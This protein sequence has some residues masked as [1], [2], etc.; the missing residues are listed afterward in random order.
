VFTVYIQAKYKA[1]TM[2]SEEKKE[3]VVLPIDGNDE[4]KN[5]TSA[6]A[7]LNNDIKTNIS[8]N[9]TVVTD[10]LNNSPKVINTPVP[11]STTNTADTS[12][13][14]SPGF[15]SRI[16][17][18]GNSVGSGAPLLGD[19]LGNVYEKAQ[20]RAVELHEQAVT[21]VER[22]RQQQ[23]ED[24]DKLNNIVIPPSSGTLIVDGSEVKA[25]SSSELQEA[26]NE[27]KTTIESSVVEGAVKDGNASKVKESKSST[28]PNV[29]SPLRDAFNIV[30]QQSLQ[31]AERLVFPVEAFATGV[32]D[33]DATAE[34]GGED[35]EDD[36][37]RYLSPD[38]SNV[39]SSR[40]QEDDSSNSIVGSPEKEGSERKEVINTTPATSTSSL[41]PTRFTGVFNATVGRY[42]RRLQESASFDSQLS[43]SSD[44]QQSQQQ[45]Q[46]R[47]VLVGGADRV[48]GLRYFQLDSIIDKN[49]MSSKLLPPT[50][51]FSSKVREICL[52]PFIFC[53]CL[54]N[55]LTNSYTTNIATRTR[56][57]SKRNRRTMD[58]GVK[59]W[60]E[61]SY[62]SSNK[63]SHIILKVTTMGCNEHNCR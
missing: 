28:F 21:E 54:Y 26:S 49:A 41:T 1:V 43:S 44:Q 12:T 31:S 36:D 39:S 55:R 6:A 24:Q 27:K 38:S 42:R 22:L 45:Q 29:S 57:S 62:Q 32:S 17:T 59:S 47:E 7:E 40:S 51:P 34:K 5:V 18:L 53:F 60:P 10:I 16:G 11:S 52:F 25:V 63:L 19:K 4:K 35:D 3:S 58:N 37:S 46:P 8:E 9:K 23:K 50:M 61:C 33:D 48:G 56:E 20:K 13:S 30:R 15:F 14:K 2:N